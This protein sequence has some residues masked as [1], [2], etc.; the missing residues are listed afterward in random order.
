MGAVSSNVANAMTQ[1]SNN[2]SS[3]ITN[4]SENKNKCEQKIEEINCVIDVHG[5]ET[6]KNYCKNKFLAKQIQK[7]TINNNLNNTIAQELSQQAT[8]KVGALGLGFSDAN[9]YVNAM[10]AASNQISNSIGNISKQTSET[11][12]DYTC[13]GTRKTIYGD[14]TIENMTDNN[15]ITDQMIDA[16]VANSVTNDI[17]QSIKQTAS[18]TVEGMTGLIFALAVLVIAIGIMFASP[19][20]AVFS[21]KYLMITI[22]IVVIL[23][24]LVVMY[25]R[26]SWPFFNDIPY[27]SMTSPCDND[28]IDITD[29][30]HKIKMKTSPL[31]YS[32]PLFGNQD[33]N[34]IFLMC[35]SKYVK[36]YNITQYDKLNVSVIGKDINS[37]IDMITTKL[38]NSLKNK[39]Y[40]SSIIDKISNLQYKFDNDDK[41][42]IKDDD[43]VDLIADFNGKFG[44]LFS[45]ENVD[46]VVV[47]HLRFIC[48]QLINN[49]GKTPVFDLQ[50]RIHDD[51]V[52]NEKIE[53]YLY[54][55]DTTNL[56]DYDYISSISSGGTIQGKFGVCPNNSYKLQ[57]F[58][59]KGGFAIMILMVLFPI[60]YLLVLKPKKGDVKKK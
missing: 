54:T 38:K 53:T 35:L 26:K 4:N 3:S 13:I 55:P 21:S 40:N 5:K 59:R 44:E 41:I 43:N 42:V 48:C 50:I 29:D 2:V 16:G 30:K 52:E 37:F 58:I 20:K 7:S 17:K 25:L 23:I 10:V 9:N 22:I 27:V 8:S 19:V 39:S 45:L 15:F 57:K 33:K 47:K 28:L 46:K 32:L 24:I 36:K 18:A 31:R 6:M 1:V 49:D 34:N 11:T 51:L 60:I 12:Q 56:D 14:R